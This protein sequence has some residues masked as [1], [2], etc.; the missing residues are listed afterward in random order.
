ML[1]AMPSCHR[2]TGKSCNKSNPRAK[3]G[4]TLTRVNKDLRVTCNYT[5]KQGIA[6]YV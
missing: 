6:C 5:C 4:F 3:K 2:R 1:G